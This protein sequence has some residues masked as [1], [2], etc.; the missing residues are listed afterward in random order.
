MCEEGQDDQYGVVGGH[1]IRKQ[2]TLTVSQLASH[3]D[4]KYLA[5]IRTSHMTVKVKIE[6]MEIM[7]ISESDR[8]LKSVIEDCLA[9]DMSMC[10]LVSVLEEPGS[11]E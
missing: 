7:L 10:D 5:V 1:C 11:E 8:T 6:L 9:E 4:A 2:R 3:C